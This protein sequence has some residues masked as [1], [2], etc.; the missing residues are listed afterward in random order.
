MLEICNN[1]ICLREFHLSEE[2]FNIYV[3]WM[4][5]LNTLAS[6]GRN[7]YRLS[8]DLSI[9]TDYVKNLNLSQNDSFFSVYYKNIFIG[10]FKVGH[11]D[12]RSGVGDI[13]LMIGEVSFRNKGLSTKILKT[14]LPYCFNNLGLRRLSGGA[15]SNNIA[16]CKCFERVGF[17][18]EGVLRKALYENGSYCDHILYGLLRDEYKFS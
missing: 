5:D 9:I 13:G 12:W 17:Q 2:E 7:E 1:E 16:M 3:S 18:K 15:L 10:T 8:I 4:R 6:I 14:A 11:I